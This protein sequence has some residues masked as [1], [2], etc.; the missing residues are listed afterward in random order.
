VAT[1]LLLLKTLPPGEAGMTVTEG[2]RHLLLM[3]NHVLS[4]TNTV[5]WLSPQAPP[6]LD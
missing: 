3:A 2:C 4:E 1:V 5:V 6:L